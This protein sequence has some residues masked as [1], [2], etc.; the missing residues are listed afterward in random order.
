MTCHRQENIRILY[1]EGKHRSMSLINSLIITNRSIVNPA[2]TIKHA[3]TFF[4]FFVDQ[5]KRQ[6]MK[7]SNIFKKNMHLMFPI[8]N[9]KQLKKEG[10]LWNRLKNYNLTP[11]IANR[12]V[13]SF[14]NCL[15]LNSN[16]PNYQNVS[17]KLILS[18][19]AYITTCY[20][21]IKK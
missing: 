9:I 7:K 5:C 15:R 4:F 19:Y 10:L 1:G 20:F 21:S 14:K 16:L 17:K 13:S 6:N 8:R 2:K 12:F 18:K 3:M 11:Q